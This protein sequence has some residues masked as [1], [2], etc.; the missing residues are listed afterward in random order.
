MPPTVV[1]LLE[2]LPVRAGDQLRFQA[3]CRARTDLG[4]AAFLARRV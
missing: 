2:D 3:S 1:P 4:E